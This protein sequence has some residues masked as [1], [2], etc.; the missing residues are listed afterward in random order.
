M[1]TIFLIIDNIRSF[2]VV[3]NDDEDLKS[4][5]KLIFRCFFSRKFSYF[6]IV[7]GREKERLVSISILDLDFRNLCYE[8]PLNIELLIMIMLF[9]IK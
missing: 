9:I 2:V 4:L 6:E 1:Q 5:L 3:E 7:L 8:F